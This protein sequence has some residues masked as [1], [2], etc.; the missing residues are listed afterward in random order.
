MFFGVPGFK[1]G[2]QNCKDK[3][4]LDWFFVKLNKC[5]IPS[6]MLTRFF[7]GQK[8][9]VNLIKSYPHFPGKEEE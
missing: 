3:V 1:L 9:W 2:L 6:N 8:M 4:L 7:G 5:L